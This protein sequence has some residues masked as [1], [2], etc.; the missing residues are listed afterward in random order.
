MVESQHSVRCNSVVGIQGK[1]YWC[2]SSST[3]RSVVERISTT[4]LASM[5]ASYTRPSACI[6]SLRTVSVVVP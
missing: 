1:H 2:G 3:A 6:A 5:W 4:I